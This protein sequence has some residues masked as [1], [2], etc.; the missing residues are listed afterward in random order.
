MEPPPMPPVPPPPP[1][2]QVA[3]TSTTTMNMSTRTDIGP[4]TRRCITSLLTRIA[5]FTL[6]ALPPDIHTF[7]GP[8][9]LAQ[10]SHQVLGGA[11]VAEHVER[12][13][14]DVVVLVVL[15]LFFEGVLQHFEVRLGHR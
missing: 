10:Q 14:I 15:G 8:Q 6:P 7:G 13:L 3:S 9:G 12:A 4:A 5:Q 1:P 2:P 11:A